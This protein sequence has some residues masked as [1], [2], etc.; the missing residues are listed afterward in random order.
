MIYKPL[1]P[2]QPA[3]AATLFIL[4]KGRILGILQVIGGFNT[5]SE[6]L[7]EALIQQGVVLLEHGHEVRTLCL[8]IPS[9]HTF[10]GSLF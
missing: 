10:A 5:E 3:L 9:A 1:A 4:S 6:G 8:G 2:F 7:V